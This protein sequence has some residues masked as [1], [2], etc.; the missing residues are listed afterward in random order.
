VSTI[1]PDLE[2]IKSSPFF[3]PAYYAARAGVPPEEAAR[4]YLDVGA[5]LGLDPSAHFDAAH[6]R[7]RY[8]SD[9]ATENPLLHYHREGQ[10]R[11][12][13]P[14]GG[15][16]VKARQSVAAEAALGVIAKTAAA[17]TAW[18]VL[19]SGRDEV[20]V[21][22]H[23]RSHIV[24]HE[25][26]TMILSALR[27]LG[28]DAKGANE[29]LRPPA[30][31]VPLVIAPHDFFFLT[32]TKGFPVEAAI[33]VNTEQLQSIWLGRSLPLLFRAR[34]VLDINV[35][36]GAALADLGIPIRFLPLGYVPDYPVFQPDIPLSAALQDQLHGIS[37]DPGDKMLDLV[38]IGSNSKRR[39]GYLEQNMDVLRRLRCFVRLV[40]VIGPLRSDH[41]EAISALEYASLAQRS[42]ILLNVHHFDT[43]YF[44]WQ[45]LVHF[46][47][48]QGACVLTET[49]SSVPHLISG[50]HYLEA[51]ADELAPFAE[52]LSRDPD[53]R[54]LARD[55]AEKG[56]AAARKAFDLTEGLRDI[57]CVQSDRDA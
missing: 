46:G 22:V 40:N 13:V 12:F 50:E 2:L 38:W 27:S 55:V 23:S 18:P 56:H 37:Y 30:S 21:F 51:D 4:H 24:F 8:Q 47:F 49:A 26:R 6:Y 43:P 39:L 1:P 33:V 15:P 3:D 35:Q 45:R 41:P 10:S 42:R 29:T 11:G 20:W 14:W 36:T 5:A 25:F 16:W 7:A 19:R 32:E 52:W 53:G 9:A 57:F 17:A 48:L 31:V 54:A 28:I 44:E 34:A